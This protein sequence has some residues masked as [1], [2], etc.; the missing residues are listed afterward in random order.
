VRV[1]SQRVELFTLIDSLTKEIAPI[2]EQKHLDFVTHID[3]GVKGIFESSDESMVTIIIQNLISNAV[4]YTQQDGKVSLMVTENISHVTVPEELTDKF[5]SH[6]KGIF[7]S[8]RDSGVG[9]PLNQHD[10]IFSKLFRAENAL[11]LDVNGTGLGLYITQSF[12]EALG[13]YIWFKSI[14]NK[15]TTFTC[16]LPYVGAHP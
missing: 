11:D 9:I 5:T 8:V 16:F 10:K 15:G 3:D 14:E 1:K 13:G 12:V 4:K 6:P 7:L 2:I